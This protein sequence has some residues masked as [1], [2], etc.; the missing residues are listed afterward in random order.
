[1]VKK[2]KTEDAK[3]T[4]EIKKC[5]L[6]KEE[7][8][9]LLRRYALGVERHT[10]LELF[11]AKEVNEQTLKTI[12]NKIENQY[13]RLENG[14]AQVKDQ[15][16]KENFYYQLPQK[17]LLWLNN[18]KSCTSILQKQYLFY[19]SRAL[20]TEKVLAQLSEFQQQFYTDCI[21]N[22]CFEHI[23]KQYEVWYENANIK[24]CKISEK[25]TQVINK[26]EMKLFNNQLVYFEE[27]LV[28]KLYAKHIM[29]GKLHHI[30]KK[31]IWE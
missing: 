31:S 20:V 8:A 15:V 13:I 4:E 5:H 29:N 27:K 7:F 23:I 26:T 14:K 19:R 1:M 12:L 16:E 17:I 6:A 9:N 28:D 22:E 11:E 30:L 3:E 25:I 24:L 21:Y 10:I 2:Y 18:R